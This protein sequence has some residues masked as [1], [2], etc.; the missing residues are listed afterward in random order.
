[1]DESERVMIKLQLFAML[2]DISAGTQPSG[3]GEMWHVWGHLPPAVVLHI[4]LLACV[5]LY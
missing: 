1:M 5:R 2:A 4:S 3:G